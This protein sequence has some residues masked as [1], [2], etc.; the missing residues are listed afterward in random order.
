MPAPD[1]QRKANKKGVTDGAR[2]HNRWSHNPELYRLSYGHHVASLITC[3][4]SI[5]ESLSA[6]NRAA[7]KIRR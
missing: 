3:T 6:V 2:T 7:A 1:S 4:A 5:A